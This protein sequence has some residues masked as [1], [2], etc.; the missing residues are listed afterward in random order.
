MGL[1][2]AG[3]EGGG[4]IYGGGGGGGGGRAHIREEKHFNLLSVKL[5]FLS[6]FQYKARISAFF[7]SCKMF[8]VNNKD[9]RTR[10]VNDKVKTKSVYGGRLI[11]GMLIGLH[12]WGAY[13]RRGTY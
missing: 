1:Y 8:K 10:K 7:T 5:T 9:T 11:F 3:E 6:F 13:I 12:I 2:S 4:F